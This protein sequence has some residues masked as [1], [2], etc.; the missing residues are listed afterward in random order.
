MDD[1]D[2]TCLIQRKE[3]GKVL[4]KE[5]LE[6]YFD[7][8]VKIQGHILKCDFIRGPNQDPVKLQHEIAPLIYNLA[9]RYPHKYLSSRSNFAFYRLG[10]NKLYESDP[11][12]LMPPVVQEAKK[13]AY[14]HLLFLRKMF[15]SAIDEAIDNF[16][17]RILRESSSESMGVR[18]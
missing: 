14:E 11:Y 4:L 16:W 12:V 8:Y 9:E 13:R 1:R 7:F 3:G 2:M 17:Q 18:P 10:E 5:Y 15:L 6:D